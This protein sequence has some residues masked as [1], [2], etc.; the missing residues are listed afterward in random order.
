VVARRR[1]IDREEIIDA[2][3]IIVVMIVTLLCLSY[4]LS[5]KIPVIY[6]VFS[7]IIIIVWVI[8]FLTSFAIFALRL[9]RKY[10]WQV[11]PLL[12]NA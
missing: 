8:P 7:W 12:K 6:I 1:K 3:I 11:P 4:L 9:D 10:L 5:H 2:I